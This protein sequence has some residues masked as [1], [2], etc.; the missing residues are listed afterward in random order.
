MCFAVTYFIVQTACAQIESV[1]FEQLDS[2][3]AAAQRPV[4][5][6]MHTTWCKF[7]DLMK[8]TTF[9]N[10]DVVKELN[11]NFYFISFDAEEKSDVEF[12]GQVFKYSP[13]GVNTGVHQLAEHFAATGGNAAYPALYFLTADYKVAFQLQGYIGPKDFLEVLNKAR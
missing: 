3:Q 2:L 6:F 8:N 9:R 4:V 5:V 13:K 1:R 11:T 12:L 7:C 10:K